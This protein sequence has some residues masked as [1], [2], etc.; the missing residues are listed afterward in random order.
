MDAAYRYRNADRPLNVV[1]LSDGMTEQREQREL[2]DLIANR[3]SGASVFCVG[4]GNDVNRPLLTQLANQAG[5]LAAFIS[6][7]DDFNRQ[8]EA[9]RRKLTRPAATNV[10]IDLAGADVY[11]VEP[12]QLPNLYHGQPLRVYGRY[13]KA[14][15]SNVNVAA[16]ILGS[17]LKQTIEVSL[18]AT[19]E[20]N[21]QI[22][23]MWAWHRVERLMEESRSV[24]SPG[25]TQDE[26]V[27]LCE[28]YSITSEYASF[29]VLE[30]DAEY[31]RW[32]IDRRNATRIV[33]DRRSQ[34][35]VRDKLNE[36]RRQTEQAV[37][38]AKGEQTPKQ[39]NATPTQPTI[40]TSVPA[41]QFA[42]APAA[43]APRRESRDLNVPRFRSSGGGGGGA[44]DPFTASAALAMA[45]AALVARRRVPVR[46]AKS[47]RGV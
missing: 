19:D 1:V 9:F 34:E 44:I 7:G 10:K 12:R 24:G 4:V 28:G 27:R 33:R 22:E 35:A 11:D 45:S 29:I 23:R 36:L 39:A 13:R 3:P 42:Q 6:T 47:S 21:P 17:P 14:G 25:L 15:P 26:I 31:G 46:T 8:A 37:G 2:L 20:A 40:D 43:E 30:N 16:D 5:G 18:P 32:K 41:D 38:P